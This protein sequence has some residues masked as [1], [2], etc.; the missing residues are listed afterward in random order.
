MAHILIVDDDP[1]IRALISSALDLEGHSVSEADNGKEAVQK[2]LAEQFDLVI[3]D[4]VMPERDGL[5]TVMNIRRQRSG[6]PIIVISG[7]PDD[8]ALYLKVAEQLGAKRSLM[9]PFTVAELL[10]AVNDA[11]SEPRRD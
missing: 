2:M 4:I 5:E 1:P 10:A 11:L 8:S 3:T 7:M 6:I 9:K